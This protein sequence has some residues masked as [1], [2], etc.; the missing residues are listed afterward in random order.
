MKI[1]VTYAGAAGALGVIKMVNSSR[2]KDDVEIIAVDSNEHAV[3]LSWVDKSYVI[4]NYPSGES[5]LKKI[6]D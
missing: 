2:Y 5:D 6:S 4:S 1:M 3:G